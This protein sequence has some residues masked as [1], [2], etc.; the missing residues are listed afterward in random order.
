MLASVGLHI[1]LLNN[2]ETIVVEVQLIKLTFKHTYLTSNN[3]KILMGAEIV[4]NPR[5]SSDKK[6]ETDLQICYSCFQ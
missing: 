2:G 1:I 3:A 5:S 4:N 6:S